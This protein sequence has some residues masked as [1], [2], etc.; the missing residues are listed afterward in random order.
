M[1][2][3]A[4]F[5]NQVLDL[6]LNPSPHQKFMLSL[7]VGKHPA[8]KFRGN[9]FSHFCVIL[10]TIQPTNKQTR[11]RKSPNLS[12]LILKGILI[13]LP[14]LLRRYPQKQR[15]QPYGG[16]REKIK[17]SS[18]SA[19]FISRARPTFVQHFTTIPPIFVV[20]ISVLTNWRPLTWLG[21][22][23]MM[24][25]LTIHRSL[26]LA[27]RLCTSSSFTPHSLIHAHIQ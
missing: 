24:Q 8:S 23:Q 21:N 2:K 14:L 4:Q 5:R 12:Q 3:N 9:L 27:K 11:V 13:T 18:K 19:G 22:I 16:A 17:G 6:S 10:P 7:R 25:S 1:L 15:S 20:V 26:L